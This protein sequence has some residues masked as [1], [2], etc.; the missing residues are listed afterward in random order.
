MFVSA[1]ELHSFFSP[2]LTFT[3]SMSVFALCILQ[4]RT[5]IFKYDIFWQSVFDVFFVFIFKCKYDKMRLKYIVL[6]WRDEH[7]HSISRMDVIIL[8]IIEYNYSRLIQCEILKKPVTSIHRSIKTP[9][10]Q[11]FCKQHFCLVEIFFISKLMR[12]LEFQV[13]VKTM[14]TIVFCSSNLVILQV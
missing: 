13:E 6:R 3:P 14:Y 4:K 8:F 5:L 9:K 12:N 11:I 1:W 7:R 10:Y 2:I